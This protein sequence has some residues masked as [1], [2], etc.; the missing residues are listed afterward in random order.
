MTEQDI[1]E[2]E[3]A[4]ATGESTVRFSDGRMI[5]YRSVEEMLRAIAYARA[6]MK[7][8]PMSRSTGASFRRD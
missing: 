8:L 5:V 1:E 7:T 6:R 3:K 2:L 4:L